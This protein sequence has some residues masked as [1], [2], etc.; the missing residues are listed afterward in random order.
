MAMRSNAALGMGRP[1]GA[2]AGQQGLCICAD[3]FGL[4]PAIDEA[5]VELASRGRL[6]AVSVMSLG[7]A[8]AADAA[9]LRAVAGS[10]VDIGLHLDLTAFAAAGLRHDLP[11][12]IVASHLHRIDRA[13]LCHEIDRQ[14]EAFER[15]RG[16]PPDHVDGHQ[17]VHHLPVVRDCLVQCLLRRWPQHRP[18]LRANR[19]ARLPGEAPA[20]RIKS[21]VIDALGANALRHLAQRHGLPQNRR[22]L[23]V[24]DFRGGAPRYRQL[25]AGWLAAATDGDVLMCHPARA[26]V[27]GDPI[28]A[29]RVAEFTVL[30][31]D[32]FDTLR[33]SAG[34]HLARLV[35]AAAS[36]G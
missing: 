11:W 10:G 29:A 13:A 24:Y 35:P 2:H 5:I 30:A 16:G 34:L 6:Q 1:G 9:A 8:W 18:W 17:H 22:L 33:R 36:A 3:D 19:P 14:C 26:P 28:A 20:E 21:A 31:S 7:P 25:L 15:H 4:H 12:W 27:P 32:A 23:G